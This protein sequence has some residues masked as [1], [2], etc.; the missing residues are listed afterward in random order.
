MDKLLNL[1]FKLRSKSGCPWDRKQTLESLR[2][3]M[4]EESHEVIE[5]I[6]LKDKNK[7]E[8]EL[9]DMLVVISM[10]ITIG[11][12]K[13]MFSKKSILKRATAKMISRHPHVFGNKKAKSAEEAFELWTQAKME[14]K[15][16]AGQKSILE[17]IS[18]HFPSLLLA[19]KVQKKAARVGFDWKE[20]RDV[21]SKIDEELKEL[22]IELKKG[23]KARVREEMGDFLFSAV[24]LARK[25]NIDPEI[26]LKDAVRKFKKRFLYIEQQVTAS[27]RDWSSYSL[28]ELE[29]YWRKAK[30]RVKL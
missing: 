19:Y 9:G 21:I 17:D 15:K 16:Q 26:A 11:E 7:I 18:H 13:K 30:N 3:C 8:E 27:K 29:R 28:E 1:M 24:N 4:L 14:E 22:K 6:T 2:R 5:A 23:K 25:L 20:S 12:E 10:L